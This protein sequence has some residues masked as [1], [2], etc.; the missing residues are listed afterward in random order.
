LWSQAPKTRQGVVTQ[1]HR[2]I[3]DGA[4]TIRGRCLPGTENQGRPR[5]RSDDPGRHFRRERRPTAI[6]G[7]GNYGA[8]SD[9]ACGAVLANTRSSPTAS[10]GRHRPAAARPSTRPPAEGGLILGSSQL[11]CGVPRDPSDGPT[12]LIKVSTLAQRV[13][14]RRVAHVLDAEIIKGANKPEPASRTGPVHYRTA[15]VGGI[16]VF[17]RAAGPDSAPAVLLLHGFPSSSRMFRNLI[18]GSRTPTTP[19]P[20]TTPLTVG[21]A[22]QMGQLRADCG[23]LCHTPDAAHSE[24]GYG[25]PAPGPGGP[26]C[27]SDRDADPATL[28]AWVRG[29]WEIENRLHWVRD[30]TYQEDKSLVRTGNAPPCDGLAAQPGHQSAALGRPGQHRRR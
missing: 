30:V 8:G 20:R 12:P 1:N 5:S 21:W 7:C 22:A 4:S 26:W 27:R 13:H 25:T 19:S 16:S 28:A 11:L 18:P 15:A 10:A 2:Q 14:N 23:R 9:S 24:G 3:A 29:H 17:Y 6:G